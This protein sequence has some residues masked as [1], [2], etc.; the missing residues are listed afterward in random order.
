MEVIDVVSSD[1]EEKEEEEESRQ[2]RHSWIS[3]INKTKYKL[4]SKNTKT[5]K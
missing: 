2:I 3:N 4:S 1:V 5:N